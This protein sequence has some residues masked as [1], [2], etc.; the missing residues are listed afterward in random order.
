MIPAKPLSVADAR[1]SGA[2]GSKPNSESYLNSNSKT[3]SKVTFKRDR[4]LFRGSR[5]A[6]GNRSRSSY[7]SER[8]A[9]PEF[10]SFDGSYWDDTEERGEGRGVPHV[11]QKGSAVRALFPDDY[12]RDAARERESGR[13]R[14]AGKRKALRIFGLKISAQ[15]IDLCAKAVVLLLWVAFLA[16]GVSLVV[17]N[18]PRGATRV[19]VEGLPNETAVQRQ[20]WTLSA[21]AVVIGCLVICGFQLVCVVYMHYR[22]G[23]DRNASQRVAAGVRN[24][25]VTRFS[26][27]S[28]LT[29]TQHGALGR[30][31]APARDRDAA[32]TRKMRCH[33]QQS[34]SQSQTDTQTDS[35]RDSS[36]FSSEKLEHAGM[37]LEHEK[38]KS[39]ND[40]FVESDDGF[41]GDDGL[42]EER[43]TSEGASSPPVGLF[44]HRKS[45]SFHV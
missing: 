28:K 30:D 11:S 37:S 33:S 45:L 41:D 24:S 36:D 3:N 29:L 39:A 32:R 44:A 6:S 2:S 7:D 17:E 12:G 9:S 23:R 19:P 34:R 8:S 31:G 10:S 13:A 4:D 27:H 16:F 35:D 40:K 42:T 21:V 26:R 22:R 20:G 14:V 25:K 15:T 43:G 1:P 38:Q 5:S 18:R